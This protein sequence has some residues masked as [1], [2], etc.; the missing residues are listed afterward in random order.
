MIHWA[1]RAAL[2]ATATGSQASEIPGQDRDSQCGPAAGRWCACATGLGGGQW[3]SW[4]GR[5]GGRQGGG[6]GAGTGSSGAGAGAV[7]SR[8]GSSH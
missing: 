3:S 1:G 6:G 4:A 7:G 2:Q 8:Q 5:G